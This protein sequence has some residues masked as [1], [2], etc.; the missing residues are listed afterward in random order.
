MRIDRVDNERWESNNARESL[1]KHFEW[2]LGTQNMKHGCRNSMS[3][4][5]IP[6]RKRRKGGFLCFSSILSLINFY[7]LQS[8]STGPLVTRD[9]CVAV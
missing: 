7:R 3:C 8:Q 9:G 2:S 1:D 4:C 5:G 6:L